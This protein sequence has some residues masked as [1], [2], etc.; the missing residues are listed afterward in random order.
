[1]TL[2]GEPVDLTATEFAVLYE[3]SVNALRTVT[4]AVLLQQLWGLEKAGEP[5]LA[6]DVVRRLRRKP[7]DDADNPRYIITESRVGYRM[8]MG[9]K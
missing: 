6:R 7:G 3:L 1:M 8:A 5:W 2:G 9:E 4:H